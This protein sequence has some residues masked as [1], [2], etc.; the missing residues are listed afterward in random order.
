MELL[1][2]T[3]IIIIIRKYDFYDANAFWPTRTRS[4]QTKIEIYAKKTV[5]GMHRKNVFFSGCEM[6]PQRTDSA[7][8]LSY[9]Y[10]SK[11]EIYYSIL[12][13][14]FL[15]LFYFYFYLFFHIF[16]LW[17]WLTHIHPFPFTHQP[18]H[19]TMF[20]YLFATMRFLVHTTHI[21]IEDM[22]SAFGCRRTE[23]Y[24]LTFGFV[25]PNAHT[26]AHTRIHD[27]S[28]RQN[29]VMHFKYIRRS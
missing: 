20:I 5:A 19:C 25:G 8:L 7:M 2:C 4:L 27:P 21:R 29:K 14:L 18:S 22:A 16:Q 23:S 26:L 9:F 13:H 15:M 3:K 12:L 1:G 17:P 10:W 6:V 24:R 11:R 28:I